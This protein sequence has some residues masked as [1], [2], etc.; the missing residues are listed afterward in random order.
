MRPGCQ[1]FYFETF[2]SAYRFAR[3]YEG[4]D[5]QAY[6]I[7]SCITPTGRH[8]FCVYFFAPIVH[9]GALE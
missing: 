6:H 5:G 1:Q 3:F 9:P 2:E 7:D 8:L 4:R